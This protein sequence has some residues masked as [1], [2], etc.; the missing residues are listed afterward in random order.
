[1]LFCE[2]LVA[3]VYVCV[4]SVACVL[5]CDVKYVSYYVNCAHNV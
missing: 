5:S 1:M 3:D 4:C 2:M